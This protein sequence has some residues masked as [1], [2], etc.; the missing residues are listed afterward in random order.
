MPEKTSLIMNSLISLQSTTHSHPVVI[1]RE[2]NSSDLE[3][4]LRFIYQGHLLIPIEETDRFLKAAE[5]FQVAGLK[6][7]RTHVP[8]FSY[9][10][11]SSSN[12]SSF[13][14]ETS[15]HPQQVH[16]NIYDGPSSVASSGL[17]SP[18]TA[19]SQQSN[20]HFSRG[21]GSGSGGSIHVT[22]GVAVMNNM[23]PPPAPPLPPQSQQTEPASHHLPP[24]TA[25]NASNQQQVIRQGNSAR[26]Q[27]HVPAG[28]V[29]PPPPP[30][31][32]A[33]SSQ[34]V[35]GFSPGSVASGAL[36]T[37]SASSSGGV[38][39]VTR[40]APES[41]IYHQQQ[42]QQV[43]IFPN[44]GP[45]QSAAGTVSYMKNEG[46]PQYITRGESGRQEMMVVQS[47]EGD[48]GISAVHVSLL[49][50]NQQIFILNYAL[51]H[52]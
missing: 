43:V 27:K 18:P 12:V 37:S 14:E 5:H 24:P 40:V 38:Q 39:V 13:Q 34:A 52:S 32:T 46:V 1:L 44:G 6:N 42:P 10:N 31:S 9:P 45:S 26:L 17:A 50:D 25:E 36:P 51:Y 21:G 48:V 23:P 30:S 28:A 8:N 3:L 2:T 16:T 20:S 41:V 4:I 49:F 7:M 47:I 22:S 11:S 33:Y 35:T 29:V 19:H 15:P